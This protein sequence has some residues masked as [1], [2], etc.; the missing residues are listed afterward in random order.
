[1]G[2]HDA[3]GF[4]FQS[5]PTKEDTRSK[6]DIFR[7][8]EKG[9]VFATILSHGIVCHR[10]HYWQGRTIPCRPGDPACKAGLLSRFHCWFVAELKNL[11]EP[12]IYEV[13][14]GPAQILEK[15]FGLRRT[16]R[17]LQIKMWRKA[18]A[19]GNGKLYIAIGDQLLE[20]S[21]L[22]TAPELPPILKAIWG[23]TDV[24]VS[25]TDELIP[26]PISEADLAQD[27][28]SSR[29]TLPGQSSFRYDH[30]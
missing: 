6:Y 23:V 22:P 13:T 10:T 29:G 16:L 25:E 12:V 19:A 14:A 1:M 18:K 27:G 9:T 24:R 8:P 30:D 4:Y 7:T 20:R 17:G 15:E 21:N 3:N 28:S 11:P 5:G 26:L 2:R